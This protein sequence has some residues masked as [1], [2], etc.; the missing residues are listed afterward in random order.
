MSKPTQ[1]LML[2]NLH[3]TITEQVQKEHQVLKE[4]REGFD[5]DHD[6]VHA[7]LQRQLFRRNPRRATER[8]LTSNN[9]TTYL[10]HQAN[11]QERSQTTDMSF[12]YSQTAFAQPLRMLE[13]SPPSQD[14]SHELT[15]RLEPESAQ[16]L[17]SPAHF[18]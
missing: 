9:R 14:N 13:S 17:I 18:V 12:N 10:D 15:L 8:E 3:E 1:E 5:K 4:Q 7:K 16:S 11:I 2:T 6:K